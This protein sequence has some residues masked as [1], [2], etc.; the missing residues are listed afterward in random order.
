MTAHVRPI[1]IFRWLGPVSL[2]P[3]LCFRALGRRVI[4]LEP[5]GP[6]RS[7]AA[8][9][10]LRRFG[11][12]WV[13]YHA[14]PGF[15]VNAD[16]AVT[17][18]YA[19][20]LVAGASFQAALGSLCECV[21][22]LAGDPRKARAL[23]FD[24]LANNLAVAASSYALAEYFRACGV[25]ADVFHRPVPMETLI[26]REG[27]TKV[28]N[29]FPPGFGLAAGIGGPRT[30][31]RALRA[32]WRHRSSTGATV[33]ERAR[34]NP[35]PAAFFVHKG[36]S[37]GRL[38]V[39]N[40]YFS[41]DPA[42]PLHPSRL[43]VVELAWML[44]DRERAAIEADYG[45]LGVRVTFLEQ[46]P[47]SIGDKLRAVLSHL[48]RRP[49]GPA[50]LA[51]AMI[52]AQIEI[53]VR[54]YR[55]SLRALDGTRLALID[56][57]NL[58]P[59]AG[60]V[61]LQSLGIRVV[62]LQERF[63]SVFHEAFVPLFDDLFVHGDFVKR[64]IEANPNADVDRI[65]VTGDPRVAKIAANRDAALAEREQWF[66]D[67]SR[68]CLVLD[69]HSPADPFADA[70]AYGPD[71]R[72]NRM[73]YDA[74]AGLAEANPDCAFVVRGKDNAWL[75]LPAMEPVRRKFA[76]LG[77]LFVDDRYDH[78]DRSYTLAAMADLVVARYTSLCDQ[79]LAAGIP[80]LIYDALPDG[81]RLISA[82]HDYAPYPVMVY[83]DIDLRERF[84][85]V[86]RRNDF[87][88]AE[89]F[90]RFRRDYYNV[91]GTSPQT[92]VRD[93]LTKLVDDRQAKPAVSALRAAGGRCLN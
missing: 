31:A 93:E 80:V 49:G 57:D 74:V 35:A 6:M 25:K 29:L 69:F 4:F 90:T 8:A 18:R 13:D 63:M 30:W 50:A 19:K 65:V 76:G 66:A 88:D 87:M 27:V 59:R 32:I 64:Q 33:S 23:L 1:V 44:S 42:S 21:P 83:D 24:G 16:I 36:L 92:R 78:Y 77:N 43:R 61:A 5:V 12:E 34:A 67:F 73:F 3:A 70:L 14:C 82:W 26:A 79:C 2:I 58:F 52:L 11:V 81:G 15:T 10:R 85:R 91:G 9:A 40:Q 41:D 71:W 68:V 62:A 75:D 89:Q 7:E 38:F 48:A 56:S 39:K 54:S 47:R 46:A 20:A 45:S 55:D 37:Y 84:D 28:R 86:I 72:S 53:Q 51:R 22:G 60:T 17:A